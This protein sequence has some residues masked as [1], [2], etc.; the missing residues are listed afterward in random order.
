MPGSKRALR[1]TFASDGVKGPGAGSFDYR[2]N[3]GED[4][5]PEPP[6]RKNI[7]PR[8]REVSVELIEL[9]GTKRSRVFEHPPR[10]PRI[11]P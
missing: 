1:K 8:A 9:G 3:K 6:R 10:T 4:I 7:I 2:A 11:L 5:L